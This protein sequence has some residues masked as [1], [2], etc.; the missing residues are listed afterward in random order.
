[1]STLE[2]V[3]EDPNGRNVAAIAKHSGPKRGKR[4]RPDSDRDPR[5]PKG[6]GMTTVPE[7]ARS[8][9]R[10]H[11]GTSQR[12]FSP[13][14]SRPSTRRG[15]ACVGRFR[16]LGPVEN[17][18]RWEGLEG[19][20]GVDVGAAA[21]DRASRRSSDHLR[22]VGSA[23]F[24]RLRLAKR[25]TRRPG[26]ARPF[27][28]L[29]IGSGHGVHRRQGRRGCSTSPISTSST[30]SASPVSS[31]SSTCSLALVAV[32]WFGT[33]KPTCARSSR[34]AA[35]TRPSR[36]SRNFGRPTLCTAPERFDRQG[37]PLP[38]AQPSGQRQKRCG[39]MRG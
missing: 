7:S 23:D 5:F 20:R 1:M 32:S 16:R 26:R 39:K 28:C 19:G 13:I 4:H 14:V 2:L 17:Q 8:F 34:S 33:S 21:A 18:L 10:G 25:R 6:H 36:L 35:S 24:G 9:P 15:S 27:H 38:V 31:S 22:R 11:L 29:D 3:M 12:T 30:R 37:T